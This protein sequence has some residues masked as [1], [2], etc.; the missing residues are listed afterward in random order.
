MEA[1]VADDGRATPATWPAASCTR[2]SPKSRWPSAISASIASAGWVLETAI[3][4]TS[5]GR[6]PASAAAL[7]IRAVT[8]AECRLRHGLCYRKRD[9]RPPPSAAPLA[10]DRRAA[11]RRAARRGRAPARG[12]RPRVPPLP[13]S[14]RPIAT[15]CSIGCG[16]FMPACSCSP[17]RPSRRWPGAPTAATGA[18]A[19][20]G[21]AARRPTISARSAPPSA[22]VPPSSSFP[23][24]IAT[25]SHPDART[26]GLARF[27]WLARRTPLPVI[28]L[29]GMNE[30]RG[31][32]L[33]SFGAY[34]W[35]GIDA[36]SEQEMDGVRA[37]LGHHSI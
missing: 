31:K 1:D 20:R 8:S 32:R 7:P 9:A 5:S 37:R 36:W 14:R 11:G 34:G 17:D 3:S 16:R 33:A 19:A 4:V 12:R 28:A 18:G 6:R 27:A 24:S 23:R 30:A 29:G 15:P 21:C 25:R 13:A 2:F 35:A 26:L 22:P 10:D